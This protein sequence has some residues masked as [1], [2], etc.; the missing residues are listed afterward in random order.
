MNEVTINETGYVSTPASVD[1]KSNINDCPDK[2]NKLPLI[3]YLCDWVD[4]TPTL[5]EVSNF[6]PIL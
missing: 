2:Y 4:I 1:M 3:E 6:K 5:F